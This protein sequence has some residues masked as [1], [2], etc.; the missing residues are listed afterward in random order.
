[1]YPDHSKV[2]IFP[3]NCSTMYFSRILC[4]A[5][6]HAEAT[7]ELFPAFGGYYMLDSVLLQK[8]H[9]CPLGYQ[10]A[11]ED[12]CVK[13]VLNTLGIPS[14]MQNTTK[15]LSKFCKNGNSF[16][17]MSRDLKLNHIYD[18]LDEYYTE[19]ATIFVANEIGKVDLYNHM[20][21]AVYPSYILC[22]TQRDEAQNFTG[23]SLYIC[24]DGPVIANVLVCNGRADCQHAEDEAQCSVCSVNSPR[25]CFNECMF[26]ACM[27][28]MYYYQCQSGGCVHYDVVCD[29]FEDCQDGDDEVM[30]HNKKVFPYF[31]QR[32]V[33]NSYMPGICD[34]MSGLLMCRSKPQCYNSSSI[35]LYDHSGGVTAY[36]E[37]GSHIGNSSLCRYIE[38]PQH[39]KC[40]GSYCI[41]IRKVCDGIVDCPVGDDEASCRGYKCPGH[42]L[43][44]GTTYCVPPHEIC[45]GVSHCPQQEDEK[46]CQAC[47]HGCHCMGSALYCDGV[48]SLPLT[49]QLKSPSALYL[50][51]TYAIFEKLYYHHR[52]IMQ[53]VQLL[54][55]KGGSFGN[56]L[57]N[58]N[59]TDILLSVKVLNLSYQGLRIL[60]P[61]FINGPRLVHVLLSNN[62]ILSVQRGAFDLM[63][64]V[65]VL[66]LVSNRLQS[67]HS[68]FCSQLKHLAYLYLNDNPL[69]HIASDVFMEN[70]GLVTIRSDWYM[71]CCVALGTE[72]C[73]PQN[74]F[75]SSC[76]NLITSTAQ[77]AVTVAQ[78]V[79]V[80]VGNTGAVIVQFGFHGNQAERYLIIS[81]AVAD[82][83]M[84][85]YLLGIASIDLSFFN[86]FYRIISE[87][88]GSL[89]CIVFG[90]INFT[91]CE[92]SLMILSI[93][94]LAR[95]ISVDK[96]GGMA[97][98]KAKVRIVCFSAWGFILTVGGI[99][100]VYVFIQGMKIRNNMCILFGISHQRYITKFEQVFQ[101]FFI[102]WNAILL[103]IMVVCML[104]IF[105]IVVKSF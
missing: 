51:D 44:H 12:F 7:E 11:I 8:R 26:P 47:P 62:N 96:V 9:M 24:D 31:D 75:I 42:M 60:G 98:I 91:S 20:S 89:A 54:S 74:Q 14:S 82:F 45:D 34:P 39:F 101:I 77:R 71:V 17:E 88:K 32:Y 55:L 22:F 52:D 63:K 19:G 90:L 83:V 36:C 84:G 94:S 16:T 81:L 23:T 58:D 79:I 97:A 29:S 33:I 95:V 80:I 65:R 50:Y 57:A 86:V 10:F 68:F 5:N 78:G 3:V 73:Q 37:D 30:C 99:Y 102:I 4:E 21:P 70:A 100:S 76:S 66:S 2:S 92:M 6:E 85:V 64:H 1:M 15:L 104:C 93:L 56:F 87:W 105:Q 59:N 46:H 53:H 25:V 40:L 43:C 61:C 67:L 28:N 49:G 48:E 41:P 27:C 103:L 38:C 13:L 72:D 18:L 69:V 35:C